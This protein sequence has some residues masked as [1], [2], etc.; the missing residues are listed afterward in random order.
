MSDL[1]QV[2]EQGFF[3]LSEA[4][5][6]SPKNCICAADATRAGMHWS[7]H[8]TVASR[9][10]GLKHKSSWSAEKLSSALNDTQV[11]ALA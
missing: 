3:G 5:I 10:R 4:D 6:E 2:V 9:R 8:M 1:S 7:P 11:S